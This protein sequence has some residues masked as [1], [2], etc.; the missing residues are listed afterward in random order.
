MQLLLFV[1]ARLP[2]CQYSMKEDKP[3]AQRQT[4]V[5]AY[6]K[7]EQLM[8]FVFLLLYLQCTRRGP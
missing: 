2:V 4:T 6:M 8:L 7:S 5:A 3:A 1:F